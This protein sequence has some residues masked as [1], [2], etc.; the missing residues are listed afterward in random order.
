MVV[1]KKRNTKKSKVKKELGYT[2]E[3]LINKFNKGK[4]ELKKRRVK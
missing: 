1:I 4:P 2:I 3:D